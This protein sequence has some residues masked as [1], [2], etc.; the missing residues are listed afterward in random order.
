MNKLTHIITRGV[1]YTW[2]NGHAGRAHTYLRLDRVIVN[3]EA[4]SF[5]D[6]ISCTSLVRCKSDH[7]PL[8]LSLNKG[9]VSKPS[10]FEFFSMW[11]KHPD[12]E[13]VVREVWSKEVAGCPM[14]SLVQKLKMLKS[15]LRTWN[16][17][18]FGDVIKVDNAY[19][20]LDSIQKDILN[21]VFLMSCSVKKIKHNLICN[22]P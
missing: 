7:Y 8:L 16:R 10:S 21:H 4:I 19:V 17:E 9:L 2:S 5:W 3:E 13:R 20:V 18:M 12:C 11:Y 1:R 22:L 15:K 14:F 6:S